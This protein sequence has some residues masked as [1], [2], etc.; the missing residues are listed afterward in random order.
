MGWAYMLHIYYI[1][2]SGLSV[3]CKIKF[4]KSTQG[5]SGTSGMFFYLPIGSAFI[6]DKGKVV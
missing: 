3:A 6:K 5:E 1:R 2:M 4:I